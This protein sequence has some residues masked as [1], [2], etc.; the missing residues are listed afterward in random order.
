MKIKCYFCGK[1]LDHPI[2]AEL[3][4]NLTVEVCG[5]CLEKFADRVRYVI[6][7]LNGEFVEFV[8]GE[9]GEDERA[10]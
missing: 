4:S 1:D 10:D 8:S 5:K 9:R 7:Y 2:I 6:T 3:K